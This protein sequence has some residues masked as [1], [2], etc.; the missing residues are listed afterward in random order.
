MYISFKVIIYIFSLYSPSQTRSHRCSVKVV[1]KG[2]HVTCV[3]KTYKAAKVG[4]A[5]RAIEK[6]KELKTES[7]FNL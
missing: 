3:A 6:I 1:D 4:A 7:N 5:K 2:I